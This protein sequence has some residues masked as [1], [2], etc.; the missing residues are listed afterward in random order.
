MKK[1]NFLPS[2]STFLVN[3]VR[4]FDIEDI[5]SAVFAH[6][7]YILSTRTIKRLL[8]KDEGSYIIS[9]NKVQ[10]VQAEGLILILSNSKIRNN[11]DNCLFIRAMHGLYLNPLQP[12]TPNLLIDDGLHSS[13]FIENTVYF[14]TKDVKSARNSTIDNR[15]IGIF[16]KSYYSKHGLGIATSRLMCNNVYSI[17]HFDL[18]CR[19]F[20]FIENRNLYYDADFAHLKPKARLFFLFG[21]FEDSNK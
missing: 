13:F 7:Q 9:F 17:S 19:F 6:N 4:Y 21:L 15:V 10:A 2:L 8:L 18:I 11:S 5:K 12:V 3:K 14:P 20:T 1:I 16:L